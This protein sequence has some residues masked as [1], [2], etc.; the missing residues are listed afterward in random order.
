MRM[1]PIALSKPITAYN[2]ATTSPPMNWLLDPAPAIRFCSKA[3][4]NF[5]PQLK[6][7]DHR[8]R[9]LLRQR[10]ERPRGRAAEQR[11]EVAPFYTR[12]GLPSRADGLQQPQPST[13]EPPGPWGKR[14]AIVSRYAPMCSRLLKL[15]RCVRGGG[16]RETVKGQISR[17]RDS[18]TYVH[19]WCNL[20][21]ARAD[22]LT[23][24]G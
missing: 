12:H 7:P 20:A 13:E 8:H 6:D 3:E 2:T 19:G 10:R 18:T 4:S 17:R 16:C 11:D 22:F 24:K 15:L 23:L 5:L 21:A 1:L 14:A 9:R